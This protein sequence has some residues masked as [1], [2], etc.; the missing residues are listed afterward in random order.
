MTDYILDAV[1]I[2]PLSRNK[3]DQA[4]ILCHGYGGDGKDISVLA[5][6]WQRFLPNV[7]FFDAS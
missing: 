2:P 4:I 3:P 1:S 7:I 5:A 6:N